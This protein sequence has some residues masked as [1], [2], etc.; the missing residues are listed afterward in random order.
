[1]RGI[2]VKLHRLFNQ[3]ELGYSLSRYPLQ[4]LRNKL[5]G[6][7]NFEEMTTMQ[8]DDCAICFELWR[9][10]GDHQICNG[11][12]ER[13]GF[14]N[15]TNK[16]KNGDAPDVR[17]GKS[18]PAKI[19]KNVVNKVA[20]VNGS[21]SR[22]DVLNEDVNV[23]SV[24][25]DKSDVVAPGEFGCGCGGAASLAHG[26]GFVS[27]LHGAFGLDIA[28]EVVEVVAVD[29]GCRFQAKRINELTQVFEPVD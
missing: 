23:R 4:A 11:Y 3:E 19:G 18:Y 25:K 2:L 24:E 29:D 5:G 6:G 1:M 10:E 27:L 21:G 8:I 14:S 20:A 13:K 28:A 7:L 22:F 26:F 12:V 15:I 17:I 16:Y 9:C